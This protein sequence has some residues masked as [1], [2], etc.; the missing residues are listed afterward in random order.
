MKNESNIR[1]SF[2]DAAINNNHSDSANI[3]RK[4]NRNKSVL[5]NLEAFKLLE[6]QHDKNGFGVL[7]ILIDFYW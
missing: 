3:M 4:K 2:F 1:T 7:K 5:L 6:T